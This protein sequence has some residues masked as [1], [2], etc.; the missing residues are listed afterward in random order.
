ML[1][2]K[3]ALNLFNQFYIFRQKSLNLLIRIEKHRKSRYNSVNCTWGLK[4]MNCPNCNLEISEID[5][6]CPFCA[7][8]IS[9]ST[10]DNHN[11]DFPKKDDRFAIQPASEYID[12]S[13]NENPDD[14]LNNSIDIHEDK[15][16]DIPPVIEGFDDL[17]T[18]E[19]PI[20][21]TI[22][23]ESTQSENIIDILK[24]KQAQKDDAFQA[25]NNSQDN[26][27]VSFN[28]AHIP[29]LEKLLL[30][31]SGNKKIDPEFTTNNFSGKAKF[32]SV[33]SSIPLMFWFPYAL[34]KKT[35]SMTFFANQSLKLSLYLILNCSLLLFFELM[36]F[37]KTVS[38]LKDGIL[39]YSSVKYVP[40]VILIPLC[41][42]FFIW[43]CLTILNIYCSIKN[44][45]YKILPFKRFSVIK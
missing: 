14:L 9:E 16:L 40:L 7:H 2:I 34:K 26:S 8:T 15:A 29:F 5:N 36:P 22:E 23:A 20:E 25:E 32:Y 27:D 28:S 24:S 4:R 31:L 38:Y 39:Y 30:I 12:Q 35:K 33:I 45:P 42:S 13:D 18:T 1:S 44:K 37:Y 43:I 17:V 19:A 6:I 3:P 11:D 10:Q 21:Q 41:V